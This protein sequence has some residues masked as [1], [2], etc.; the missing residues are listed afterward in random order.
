MSTLLAHTLTQHIR[1]IA[2]LV[3]QAPEPSAVA[4]WALREMAGRSGLRVVV[5]GPHAEP[6]ER[7][8]VSGSEVLDALRDGLAEPEDAQAT[9]EAVWDVVGTLTQELAVYDQRDDSDDVD[10]LEREWG[11]MAVR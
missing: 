6:V 2:A 1:Q 10:D 9:E 4:H 7:I 3:H 8:R 5:L 11:T